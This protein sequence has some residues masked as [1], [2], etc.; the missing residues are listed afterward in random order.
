MLVVVTGPSGCGKTRLCLE[1]IRLLPDCIWLSKVTT[2]PPRYGEQ[3]GE[4][5][6]VDKSEFPLMGPYFFETEL[7]GY[8]YGLRQQDALTASAIDIMRAVVLDSRGALELM[9]KHSWIVTVGIAPAS[10][11]QCIEAIRG[12][13]HSQEEI[14]ARLVLLDEE[15]RAA[16]S[17]NIVVSRE[18]D[19]DSVARG[20]RDEILRRAHTDA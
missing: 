13:A 18:S 19:P 17:A 7:Y 2:R 12:R 16:L 1:L 10:K 6:F 3:D 9:R 14:E 20:V 4:Y 5:I 8:Q 15:I 11:G